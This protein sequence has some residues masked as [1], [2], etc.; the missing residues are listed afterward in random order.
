MSNG[1]AIEANELVDLAEASLALG[2]ADAALQLLELVDYQCRDNRWIATQVEAL[3]CHG[4]FDACH[5][6]ATTSLDR[7]IDEADWGYARRVLIECGRVF[8]QLMPAQALIEYLHTIEVKMRKIT[9]PDLLFSVQLLAVLASYIAGEGDIATASAIV[10][11]IAPRVDEISDRRAKASILWITAEL[12]ELNGAL[13]LAFSSME[14][15]V[16][17]FQEENDVLA[18]DR[19]VGYV[20]WLVSAH[21]GLDTPYALKAEAYAIDVCQRHTGDAS[22]TRFMLMNMLARIQLQLGKMHEALQT[23]EDLPSPDGLPAELVTE[24]ELTTALYQIAVGRGNEATLHLDN[25]VAIYELSF[26]DVATDELRVSFRRIAHAYI[27]I[28]NFSKAEALLNLS[29]S[30]QDDLSRYMPEL[31]F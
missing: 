21:R 8:T 28:E 1:D 17:L 4:D 13:E 7:M 25:A 2:D 26:Q 16:C 19:A 14:A 9:E 23:L 27:D 6:L 18:V 12:A 31:K 20:V 29:A 24:L 22:M 15:V 5:E 30:P 10:D 11:C 3:R